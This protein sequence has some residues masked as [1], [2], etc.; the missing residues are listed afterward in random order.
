[1]RR[2][3]AS[4]RTAVTAAEAGLS[5]AGWP[6]ESLDRTRDWGAG[7]RRIIMRRT[8]VPRTQ[9]GVLSYFESRLD[10]WSSDP[11]GIGLSQQDVDALIQAVD[12]AKQ[13]LEDAAIKRDAARAATTAL[14]FAMARLR[15]LGGDL[16]NSVRAYGEREHNADVF[17]RAQVDPV[18]APSA[19]TPAEK[20][21]DLQP[22][23]LTG[24]LAELRW[25]GSRDRGVSFVVER[26]LRWPGGGAEAFSVAG[27]TSTQRFLDAAL[28]VGLASVVYRVTAI[29]AGGSSGPS[30]ATELF[31]GRPESAQQQAAA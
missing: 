19:S 11:A 20:P 13:A 4:V 1:M 6:I 17:V 9:R 25:Q 14:R 27:V 16:V 26:A 24:G 7:G 18:R 5:A 22:R 28:P 23:L 2:L 8:T 15:R 29:R 30:A 10:R 21:F 3:C 31:L 12:A